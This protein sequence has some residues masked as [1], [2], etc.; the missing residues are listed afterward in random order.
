MRER[1]RERERVG[2]REEERN[3][4]GVADPSSH[5][6]LSWKEAYVIGLFPS[7]R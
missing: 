3:D 4:V 2:G 5:H 1:W 7:R 6:R